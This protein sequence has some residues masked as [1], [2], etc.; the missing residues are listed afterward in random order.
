VIGAARPGHGD[1]RLRQALDALAPLGDVRLTRPQIRNVSR[2]VRYFG[3]QRARKT[4]RRTIDIE[5]RQR[6]ARATTVVTPSSRAK[7][8]QSGGG[9]SSITVAPARASSGT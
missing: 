8:L 7:R 5:I 2:N 4:A 9:A 1:A 3:A 6:I